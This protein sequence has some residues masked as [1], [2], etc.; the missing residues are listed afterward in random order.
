MRCVIFLRLA[1]IGGRVTIHLLDAGY[2]VGLIGE[3]QL[4]G[5]GAFGKGMDAGEPE[6]NK[7]RQ[8]DDQGLES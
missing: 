4:Q 2:G 6:R 5:S 8:G 7:H 1:G 3:G